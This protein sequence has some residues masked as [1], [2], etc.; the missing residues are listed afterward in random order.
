MESVLSKCKVKLLCKRILPCLG[1]L[2]LIGMWAVSGLAHAS[3][4]YLMTE[5]LQFVR[6]SSGECWHTSQ[7]RPELAVSECEGTLPEPE[8]LHTVSLTLDGTTFFD[9]DRSSLKPEARS[10]L[11]ALATELGEAERIEKVYIVGHADRIGSDAYNDAL[12]MRR[13]E[14]VRDYLL[15][16]DLLSSESITLEARGEREP[17]VAC[18]GIYGPAAVRCLAPNRR[19][20]ITVHLQRAQAAQ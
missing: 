6:N 17:V 10:K 9:F 5:D 14:T 18:E 11:D 8:T 20:E 3:P 19:V 1:G 7:W 2:L 4:G 13:A 15:Q 16:N 12:S